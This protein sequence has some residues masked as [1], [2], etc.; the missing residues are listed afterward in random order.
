MKLLAGIVLALAVANSAA[1]QEL[2]E[3]RPLKPRWISPENPTGAAGQG[4]QENRG[5][6][7]HPFDTLPAGR[8]LVLG[9]IN[10]AG[11]I[12]RI[13]ITINDRSPEMLRAL[14]LEMFWDG[15]ST[16]AVSAPLGDF[17]GASLGEIVP[18]ENSLFASPEGRSFNA[19][20]PMPFRRSA[21]IVLTNESAKDLAH[22]FYD[23]DYTLGDPPAEALYFHAYW[24]RQRPTALGEAFRILPRVTG[25][26][27]I[28]RRRDWRHHGSGLREDVVGRRRA[29]HQ[30]RRR[31]RASD[32]GRHRHRGRDRIRLGA[33][34]L[35]PP[36]PGLLV[37][38]EARRHWSFYRLHVPDA[39]FFESA[40][41]VSLQQIGGAPKA[42]V[43][44]LEAAGA[45]LT[46]ITIDAGD[47]PRFSKLLEPSGAS[48]LAAAAST[49]WVNFYRRDDVSATAYFYLDRPGSDLPPLAPVAERVA[50]LK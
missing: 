24:H 29:S 43:L 4:G 21:R 23:I 6:K 16:P 30:S 10:G 3:Y 15:A 7:G 1:S 33:G 38:D 48:A 18:F 32:A 34:A 11:V 28:S 5:A 37:A 49:D 12:R 31:R 45:A 36:L 50:G 47:R 14:R 46:P 22:V 35:Q 42:D 39:I 2:F 9:E 17:F 13:W 20:V 27:R 8:S 26:G 41:E 40:C 44:R 19:A 25:R